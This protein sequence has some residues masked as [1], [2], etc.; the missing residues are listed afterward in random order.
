[1]TDSQ[2]PSVFDQIMGGLESAIAQVRGQESLRVTEFPS[3][4]PKAAPQTVVEIR[5]RLN[6]SQ[7]VFAATL[8][9]SAKTVQG[10]ERGT[11]APSQASLRM[12]QILSA[13]PGIVAL[14]F[15]DQKVPYTVSR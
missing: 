12:L 7:S 6:M 15:S 10:W 14:L 5:K 1:M 2:F 9:V 3:P 11:R 4:P 8:N 13:E